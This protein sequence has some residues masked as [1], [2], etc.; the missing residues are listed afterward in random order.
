[1]LTFASA[2][3]LA[4][5]YVEVITN[6]DGELLRDSTIAKPY[7]WIFFYQNRE[8]LRDPTNIL[9]A[10]G[11]NAPFVVDRDTLEVRVFGT[12]WPLETYIDQYEATMPP[13]RLSG[14]PQIPS[15]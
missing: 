9:N 1:M 3:R 4:E 8:Y 11:G 6:G 2:R 10:Y 5:T 7:G 13:A 15:W 14:K 12:A